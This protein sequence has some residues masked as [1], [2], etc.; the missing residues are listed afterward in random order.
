[1]SAIDGTDQANGPGPWL[2]RFLWLSIALVLSVD[3][4]LL[5]ASVLSAPFGHDEFQHSHI[6]WNVLNGQVPYRDFFEHHG[7]L[8]PAITGLALRIAGGDA[9]FGTMTL[10]RFVSLAGLPLLMHAT[11]LLA[12]RLQTPPVVALAAPALLVSAEM[13]HLNAIEVRADTWQNVFWIYGLAAML[14][15]GPPALVCPPCAR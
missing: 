15:D 6:A 11:F 12:R 14:L 10:L 5:V 2:R 13:V 1:M 8:F 4:T 3:M 7:I 9:S